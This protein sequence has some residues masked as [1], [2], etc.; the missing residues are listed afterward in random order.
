MYSINRLTRTSADVERGTSLSMRSLPTPEYLKFC[1]LPAGKDM[2]EINVYEWYM[3]NLV[4]YSNEAY[5]V[6]A[7]ASVKNEEWV[8]TCKSKGKGF[9]ERII[10]RW[11]D[12]KTGNITILNANEYIE[13]IFLGLEADILNETKF[14]RDAKSK[15]PK[16]FLFHVSKAFDR[17]CR[18]YAIIYANECLF[19]RSRKQ[20]FERSFKQMLY[21]SWYWKLLKPNKVAKYFPNHFAIFQ[22]EFCSLISGSD[23]ER[24]NGIMKSRCR[25]VEPRDDLQV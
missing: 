2:T 1:M 21:F 24:R 22:K 8:E 25:T 4:E 13:A 15:F 10:F 18:I 23:N 3:E 5:F 19:R 16:R 11:K 6:F 14:P 20:L 9:P 12:R 7:S 17:L